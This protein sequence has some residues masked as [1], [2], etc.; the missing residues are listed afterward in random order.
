VLASRQVDDEV[1]DEQRAVAVAGRGLL[2]K[3]AVFEHAGQLDDALE[4]DLAPPAA[5]VRRSQCGPQAPGLGPQT[6]LPLCERAHLLGQRAVGALT[7]LVERPG[8]LVE[9]LQ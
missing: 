8:L 4:L 7:L 5:D 2:A 3:V 1:W 6:L 9:G